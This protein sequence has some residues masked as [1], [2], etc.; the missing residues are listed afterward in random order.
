MNARHL[1]KAPIPVAAFLAVGLLIPACEVLE[2]VGAEL[3]DHVE[4]P[5]LRSLEPELTRSPSAMDLARFYCPQV[6]GE[7]LGSAACAFGIG[8][9]PA[10]DSLR[11]DFELPLRVDN[12][13]SVPL[14]ATEVLAAIDVFRGHAQSALGAVC[15]R[16]CPAGDASC[17]GTPGAD[18]CRSSER[19]IEDLEDL[20]ENI[21]GLLVAAGLKAATGDA[22][23]LGV[24]LIPAFTEDV[25]VRVRLSL[26]L[27]PMIGVL[28]RFA[29]DLVSEVHA[30]KAPSFE[31]P[32]EVKGTMWFDL[33]TLGRAAVGYGPLDGVWP[34]E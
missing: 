11:F 7:G 15:L 14:P 12:P 8:A 16:L 18:S 30:G 4:L 28:S 6:L 17:D 5:R 34:L 21:G 1:S 10:E 31:I 19:D 33:A 22:N 27:Q 26:G 32:Y 20:K 9:A 2:R 25:E 24:R 3:A 23:D 13:N 29:D